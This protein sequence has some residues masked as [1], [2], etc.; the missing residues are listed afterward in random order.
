MPCIAQSRGLYL[1]VLSIKN[2]NFSTS[3]THS[4]H[5][6]TITKNEERQSILFENS[7]DLDPNSQNI[8]R[9]NVVIF[10]SCLELKTQGNTPVCQQRM[11]PFS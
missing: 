4:A 3:N 1:A 9:V 2:K 10:V 5:E 7:D 6:D 8:S 11:P